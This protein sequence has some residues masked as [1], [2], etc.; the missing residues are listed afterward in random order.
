[1]S[2]V[3]DKQPRKGDTI[4]IIYEGVASEIHDHGI[5]IND[6]YFSTSSMGPDGWRVEIVKRVPQPPTPADCP[7]GTI[8][9]RSH[10]D[11]AYRWV[12]D[13]ERAWTCLRPGGIA[14]ARKDNN[15]MAF[16][17]E[18]FRVIGA[19]PGTPA[20][21]WWNDKQHSDRT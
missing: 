8:A 2:T 20:E 6:R 9:V 1:M 10:G 18:M 5:V 17:T 12:K 7:V 19:V 3:D 14:E 21:Q 15:A 16:G 11:G 4:R 13:T